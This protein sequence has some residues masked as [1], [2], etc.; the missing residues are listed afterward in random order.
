MKSRYLTTLVCFL[1]I[2][3]SGTA[4]MQVNKFAVTSG[5]K[6]LTNQVKDH[7]GQVCAHIRITTINLDDTQRKR[8]KFYTDETSQILQLSWTVGEVEFYISP[9][10]EFL[11]I[12]HPDYSVLR[13]VFKELIQPKRDYEMILEYI[14]PAVEE[15]PKEIESQWLV[16]TPYPEDAMVYLDG[17]FVANGQYQSKQA[18]GEFTYKVEAPLYHSKSGTINITDQ[19]EE[20]N[21][22][23]EPAHGYLRVESKPEQ[24]AKVLV[25]GQLQTNLTPMT[26]GPLSS[27]E[28]SIQ[29]MKEMFTPF[30]QKVMVS[31]GQT[32]TLNVELKPSFAEVSI[33]TISQASLFANGNQV[34]TGSWKGRLNPGVYSLEA[35]LDK[36]HPAK[37]D[38]ELKA[39][40][41]IEI[42]LELQ[43][44]LGNLD[45]MTTPAGASIVLNGKQYGTSPQTIKNLLIGDY[46]ISLTKDGYTTINKKVSV[47]EGQSIL[48]NEKLTEKAVTT[49]ETKT[50]TGRT[51]AIEPE[52]V[53]VK[54]GTFRMGA[55]SEQG[56]NVYNDEKPAH[57]VTLSDYYIGKYEVTQAQWEAVM[58]N[59][60]SN[61]KRDPNRPVEQVSWNDVQEYITKLNQLTG[62]TYRLPTEAEWE[63]AARGGSSSRGY[64]YSGSNTL[65]DVAWYDDN[66]NDETHPV[67]TKNPNELGIYDMSGNVYEWCSD[68]YGAYSSNSQTNPQ[69][70]SEGSGRVGRGGGW[71]GGAGLCRV[72]IRY[73]ERADDRSSV[74]GF[75]LVLV[76]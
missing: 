18:P 9:E 74:L 27:G 1:L 37:Q 54:G 25:D 64:K 40:D 2:M 8:L 70:P 63:Y 6:A 44:M 42:E 62:K 22:R 13:Y 3:T 38:V 60:P 21:I 65:S 56:Y 5:G 46:S 14:P 7:N 41:V 45:I 23:L 51:S 43:A 50:T 12:A 39:G 48:I 15:A 16:I 19:K 28:H 52:M 20:L 75:R 47:S 58:G 26:T 69:G 49:T 11:R 73:G 35:K 36:H 76:P 61:F 55:T 34:G 4:Q 59:N 71:D 68:W 53:F 30:T 66:S 17:L 33:K 32:N 29:V 72:S 31:D 10:A 67:G 57:S 24:G